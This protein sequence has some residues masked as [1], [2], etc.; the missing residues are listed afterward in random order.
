MQSFQNKKIILAITVDVGLY[1]CIEE[2][3]KKIGFEVFTLTYNSEFKYPSL[4][5][6]V[7]NFIHKNLLFDKGY[8]ARLKKELQYKKIEKQIDSFPKTD[9]SLTIRADLFKTS[10]LNKITNLGAKNY[11]YQWDGLSRFE[12]IEKQMPLFD[13]FYVFDKNDIL[14]GKTYPATNFYFDCF[15][16][17]FEENKPEYDFFY[18]GSYDN[19]IDTLLIICDYLYRKNY[20]LNIILRTVTKD[21]LQNRPY[22]SFIKVPTSYYENLEKTANSKFLIDLKNDS[23]HEGL[24]FRIFEALGSNKKIITNNQIVKNYDFYDPQNILC[25]NETLDLSVIDQFLNSPYKEINPSIKKK[26]SFTNW[27]KYILE[28]NDSIPLEIP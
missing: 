20:K 6:K 18:I 19:R 14:K 3:L 8:K 10:I 17:L 26:Y 2:N 15:D 28:I 23:V 27:I 7:L 22:I 25:L 5:Y 11:A 24:S 9:Y 12:G 1:S 21:N 13:A 16:P 4:K